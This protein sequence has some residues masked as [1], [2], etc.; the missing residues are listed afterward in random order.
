[1]I[2]AME[3]TPYIFDPNPGDP[4]L[5]IA[6]KTK[7]AYFWAQ[8]LEVGTNVVHGTYQMMDRLTYYVVEPKVY[9][10]TE[11]ALTPEDFI[12]LIVGHPHGGKYYGYSWTIHNMA[13]EWHRIFKECHPHW[14]AKVSNYALRI[15]ERDKVLAIVP[16]G[17]VWQTLDTLPF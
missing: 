7:N 10:S 8:V 4:F 2:P 12:Q 15:N 3:I 6:N 13:Q 1:M 5:E 9:D 16:K 14:D 17:E 11:C